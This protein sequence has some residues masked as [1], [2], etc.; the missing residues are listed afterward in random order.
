[1]IR[2]YLC[3]L[4]SFNAKVGKGNQRLYLEA[5]SWPFWQASSQ[6]VAQNLQFCRDH[7]V[8]G[9]GVAPPP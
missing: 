8:R 4:R 2:A 7:D 1:M 3:E 9:G 6:L 5:L